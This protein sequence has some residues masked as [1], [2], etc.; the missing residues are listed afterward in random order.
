MDGWRLGYSDW[1]REAAILE[2]VLPHSGMHCHSLLISLIKYQSCIFLF[3]CFLNLLWFSDFKTE[4]GNASVYIPRWLPWR[5]PRWPLGYF[6]KFLMDGQT[7]F[8]S[9]IS[10]RSLSLMSTVI[11]PSSV[12]FQFIRTCLSVRS[13]VGWWTF[14]SQ[15][16]ERHLRG[17]R[18]K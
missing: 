6:R 3:C 1:S 13:G 14:Y 4:V 15:R 7:S 9:S 12:V 17:V 10:F 2:L 18:G 11:R 5:G 8:Y 16:R